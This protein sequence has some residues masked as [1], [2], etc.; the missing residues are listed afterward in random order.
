LA[1][2]PEARLVPPIDPA[3]YQPGPGPRGPLTFAGRNGTIGP[4]SA[5]PKVD[6]PHTENHLIEQLPRQ[7]RRHLLALCEPVELVLSEVLCEAGQVMHH[8]YFPVNGFIS[9]VASIDGH[10]GLEVGMVGR[11]GV[12]GAPLSL[13]VPTAPLHALV[14]GA[15]SAWRIGSGNFLAELRRNAAL[16][17][18]LDR[19]LYVRIVQLASAATCLRYHQIGP[20]LAR[21]LMSQDRAHADHFH[22]THE[23]LAYMLGVRRVGVTVAAGA[24]QRAGLITYRRGEVRVLDR[25]GLEAA[26]CSC[27]ATDRQA[28]A[29]LVR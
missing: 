5:H 25:S 13:G 1:S 21:W 28:Y 10:P 14:Q 16:R 7:D 15:G 4:D 11:E 29:R 3:E 20:R 12:L 26:A 24:L 27:Y 17:K 6:V 2:R 18:S 19:Y 23:F 9:L 8:V 22:V